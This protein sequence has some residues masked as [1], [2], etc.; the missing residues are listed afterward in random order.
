MIGIVL[1]KNIFIFLSLSSC[2]ILWGA[3]SSP[4]IAD[5]MTLIE[6]WKDLKQFENKVI[7]YTVINY[8]LNPD[9]QVFTLPSDDPFT[10]AAYAVVYTPPLNPM[11]N[12]N[13]S[14]R[15]LITF[16]K[17]NSPSNSSI[18]YLSEYLDKGNLAMRMV[19]E[20]EK[21][22]LKKAVEEDVAKLVFIFDTKKETYIDDK[23]KALELLDEG[24]NI[25]PA[26]R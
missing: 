4:T 7:T 10:G 17:K 13:S 26:K 14:Y 15:E 21:E 6:R 18:C 5:Q 1:M 2:T 3:A 24:M 16:L 20:T 11:S 19:T 23:E 25:K 8:S 9:T 12:R 22:Q